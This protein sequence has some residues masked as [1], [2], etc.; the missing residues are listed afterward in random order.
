MV[1]NEPDSHLNQSR[2]DFISRSSGVAM[3]L[4]LAG[5]AAARAELPPLEDQWGVSLPRRRLGKTNLNITRYSVGGWHLGMIKEDAE[6]KAVIEYAL[7]N[8]VR[9]FDT[10]AAYQNGRSERQYGDHLIPKYRDDIVLMSKTVG[11]TGD[12]ARAQVERSFENLKTDYIDVYLMH[13]IR[14]VEDVDG[15]LKDGVLDVLREYKAKGMIGHL[16]FSGHS[17]FEAHRYMLS[18]N[19]EDLE[20]CLMP[21]NVADPSYRSFIT[22]TMQTMND[23]DMGILAMKSL[24]NG[25]LFGEGKSGPK[26]DR[27]LRVIPEKIT[28]EQALHFALSMPVSGL[29]NGIERLSDIEH[30]LAAVK[31]FK[32][33]TEKEQQELIQIC[34]E[35]GQTGLMENFKLQ[36]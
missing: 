18:K 29:I 12:A 1:S 24:A 17:D 3:G 16:G 5:A 9:F 7:H 33:L 35:E 15:R 32:P 30:N 36:I 28:I 27:E 2:R 14:S 8:G 22:N 10:A 23:R 25:G 4:M 13:A 31:R 19:I 6:A 21:V 20:V 34:R 26:S 11:K